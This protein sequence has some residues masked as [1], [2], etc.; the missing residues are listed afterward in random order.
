MKAVIIEQVQDAGESYN[1]TVVEGEDAKKIKE[2]A[3]ELYEGRVRLLCYQAGVNRDDG[4]EYV[5]DN[6]I[7]WRWSTGS[8][9]YKVQ[10]FFNV[11][12][13]NSQFKIGT[14]SI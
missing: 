1:V 8:E 5:E 11:E 12:D 2:K 13:E 14:L 4:G 9:S 3:V 6:K 10:V 7:S